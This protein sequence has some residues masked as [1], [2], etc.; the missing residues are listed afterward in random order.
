MLTTKQNCPFK[1]NGF[2]DFV[3]YSEEERTQQFR[4]WI[5]SHTQEEG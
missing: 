3:C 5:Y 2:I 4:I 1:N